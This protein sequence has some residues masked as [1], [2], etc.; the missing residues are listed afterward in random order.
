MT[1]PFE[2]E[3]I[4]QRFVPNRAAAEFSRAADL[5]R[6]KG[7]PDQ[8][9]R[10]LVVRRAELVGLSELA[11][12]AIQGVSSIRPIDMGVGLLPPGD[13]TKPRV[14]PANAIDRWRAEL[15]GGA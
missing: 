2:P 15:D 13:R 14:E 3:G 8:T 7:T 9:D 5:L 11:Y 6:L 1:P 4:R 10:E 12:A